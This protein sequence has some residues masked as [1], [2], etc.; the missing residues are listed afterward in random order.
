MEGWLGD[1]VVLFRE[2]VVLLILLGGYTWFVR[3][4]I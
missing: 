4:V 3:K 1:L 2:P